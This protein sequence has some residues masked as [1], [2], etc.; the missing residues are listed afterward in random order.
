M[1]KINYN[2]EIQ[3]FNKNGWVVLKNIFSKTEISKIKKI[4]SNF[5]IKHISKKSFSK[6]GINFISEKVDYKN[7]N[8]FHELSK[9]K[10]INKIAKSKKVFSIAKKFL[11]SDAEF[12]CCELFAKPAKKGLPSPAHQ[13]NFYW[14]VKGSNALTIWV[15]LDKSNK[16][17]GSIFY[18][19]GSHKYGVLD[20]KPSYAKGS[21]QTI[22]NVKFLKKFSKSQPELNPGDILVHHSLVVHG[23]SKNISNFSRQGWTIQF[24]DRKA[25]YDFNQ[26]KKYEKSLNNQIQ[27]RN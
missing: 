15:A 8:S 7:I 24:K 16:K 9:S 14:A 3:Y 17:N 26:I 23:S 22:K 18:F 12:R 13:D 20:H 4:I 6:R 25:N 11:N 5:L 1:Y 10:Q 2:K 21:S 27:K 19:D